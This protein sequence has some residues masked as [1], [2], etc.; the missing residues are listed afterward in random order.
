M[1]DEQQWFSSV[2]V[3]NRSNAAEV[4]TPI[5][6]KDYVGIVSNLGM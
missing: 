6:S 4:F 3:D 5:Q 1:S 2:D